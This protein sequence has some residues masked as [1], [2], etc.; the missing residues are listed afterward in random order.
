MLD[1]GP[2]DEPALMR[3]LVLGG[4][5]GLGLA[6]VERA[7]AAGHAVRVMARNPGRAALPEGV[8][9][10]TGDVAKGDDLA[11]AIEGCEV[12]FYCVNPPIT[13]WAEHLVPLT[14]RALAACRASGARFAFPANVW[15][16]GRGDGHRVDEQRS[17]APISARGALRVAQEERVRGSGVR[18]TIVRLPEFYGPNVTTLMGAPF[19]NALLGRPIPWIG[20]L[21]V[22]VELVLMQDA[23]AAMVE[24]GLA[25]SSQDETFHLPGAA[26]I[27]MRAFFGELLREAA[28]R[29]RVIPIPGPLLSVAAWFSPMA[30]VGADLRP[31]WTDPILLDGGRYRARFGSVPATPYADGVRLTLDWLRAHPDV[32]MMYG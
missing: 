24:A 26:A 32:R 4:T 21:D 19:R 27:T 16:F 29:S 28:S 12:V 20:P 7:T 10:I 23:A 14:D 17:F 8:E 22:D 6:C 31:L 5:G 1:G 11:R 18:H 13:E 30:G 15:V 3:V 9:R 2:T 25:D